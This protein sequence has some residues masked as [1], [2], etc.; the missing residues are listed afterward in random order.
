MTRGMPSLVRVTTKNPRIRE[1]KRLVHCLR[2]QLPSQCLWPIP[3][4]PTVQLK[5]STVADL[6]LGLKFQKHQ[7]K[8]RLAP[9]FSLC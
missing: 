4:M 7:I 9:N 2:S 5:T 8:V 6:L 1:W 3:S